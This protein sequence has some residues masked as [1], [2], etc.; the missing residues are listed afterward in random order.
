[1]YLEN[2]VFDAQ[3]PAEYGRYFGQ[4]LGCEELTDNDGGYETRAV[5]SED[6]FLDL[7]FPTVDQLLPGAQRLMLEVTGPATMLSELQAHGDPAGHRVKVVTSQDQQVSLSGFYL[8]SSDPQRDAEFWKALCGWLP[9]EGSAHSVLCHPS[10]SGPV[11]SFIE[12]SRAKLPG[13]K[14]PMHLDLR[15][16]P[17]DD[18][19][20]V[21]TQVLAGGG[22]EMEHQWGQLPWRIFQDPSGN[23]FCVL[24]AYKS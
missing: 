1:M 19:E 23:E 9:V 13:E 5:F 2:L 15:L 16:E 20:A 24:A 3:N 21:I 10:G 18:L 17:G 8:Q 11:F 14:N 22:S 4:L 12:Q 7:C 6:F